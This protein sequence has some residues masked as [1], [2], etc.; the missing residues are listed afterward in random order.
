MLAADATA[1]SD[2]GGKVAS[3]RRV[4]KGAERVARFV[5]GLARKQPPDRVEVIQA[6]GAPA[7]V[8][9]SG[10]HRQ[11][12]IAFDIIDGRVRQ[13]FMVRNPEKLA[14]LLVPVSIR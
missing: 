8:V 2:G 3:A 5:V 1:C 10:G 4:V 7:L 13:L 6:N 14:R 12:L 11:T 9:W